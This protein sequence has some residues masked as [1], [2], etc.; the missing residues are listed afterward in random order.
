VH[1]HDRNIRDQPENQELIGYNLNVTLRDPE[2]F[3]NNKFDLIHSRFVLPGTR[4][5]TWATYVR[6]IRPLLQ[7]GGW[8]QIIERLAL[9]QSNNGCLT[10]QSAVELW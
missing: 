2:L 10:Y 5:R 9:V 8:V 7:S 4:R 3:Q 6:D 1:L